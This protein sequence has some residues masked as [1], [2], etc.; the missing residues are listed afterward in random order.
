MRSF[1]LTGLWK[2]KMHR[3]RSKLLKGPGTAAIAK[4]AATPQPGGRGAE[5]G[6]QPRVVKE[7][8][9][10]PLEAGVDHV[11][12]LEG[13]VE[14]ADEGLRHLHLNVACRN[15]YMYIYIYMHVHVHVHVHMSTR[16]VQA[17]NMHVL[18][19]IHI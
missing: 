3:A 6:R 16:Q 8:A 15:M 11:R 13:V 9:L 19:L 17:A 18:S 14:R 12:D 7:A 4:R 1:L 2:L 10:A 5:R